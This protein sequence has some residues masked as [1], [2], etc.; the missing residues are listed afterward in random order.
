MGAF[1]RAVKKFPGDYTGNSSGHDGHKCKQANAENHDD[2]EL[3]ALQ[4]SRHVRVKKGSYGFGLFQQ[5]VKLLLS[6]AENGQK[7]EKGEYATAN[8]AAQCAGQERI[9]LAQLPVFFTEQKNRQS[10]T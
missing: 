5:L 2:F 9:A 3:A 10:G 1:C 7:A 4:G 8:Q 6:D